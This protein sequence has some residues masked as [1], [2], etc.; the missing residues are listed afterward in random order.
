MQVLNRKKLN[1][2]VA[3]YTGK[4]NKDEISIQLFEYNTEGYTE[5]IEYDYQKVNEFPQDGKSHWLNVHGIHEPKVIQHICS[6]LGIHQLALQDIL[7]I[8]QRPKFQEYDDYWFFSLKSILPSENNHVNLEQI[9][10]V[11]GSNFLVSFQEKKAD[12]FDHIRSRI[13][14]NMGIVRQRGTDFLLYLL[15][16]S[17]LDN[18]FK[19]IAKIDDKVTAISITN[20]K[21]DLTPDLLEYIESFKRQIYQIK[22]NVAPIRD[23]VSMIEREEFQMIEPK[24]VKYYFEIKDLCLTLIDECEQINIRLESNINLF[25]SVQGDRMNQVMKTLTIVATFFIPL[26]FVA[27]IYGMN[28]SNMPELG[29]KYGYLG[30]WV[31]M[32]ALTI[33]MIIYFK[34]KRWF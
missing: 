13:R 20:K 33:V 22:R 27:G 29:W 30:V 12:H 11:L 5:D 32:I 3:L 8:N 4:G 1:P 25:F 21:V 6:E 7:D 17:I 23:F 16:E 9:S 2:A 31:L 34:R 14:Q 26:T 19:T 24:H 10:F 15:L 28:F 18:Y